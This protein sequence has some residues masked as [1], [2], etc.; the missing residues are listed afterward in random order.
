[1]SKKPHPPPPPPAPDEPPPAAET[2]AGE[3]QAPPV[4][5][6]AAPPAPPTPEEVERLRA[7]A[8]DADDGQDRL[9]R[10]RAELVNETKRIARQAEQDRR[11]AVEQV[12]KDLVP[13]AEGL[14]SA[15]SAAGSA[16]SP[17]ALKD[18]VA[19]VA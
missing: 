3:Q 17:T 1:M 6:A 4:T 2:P 16:T 13:L 14:A 8:A 7:A 12:V 9:T 10:T 11:F 15:L 18:G 19:L 5:D